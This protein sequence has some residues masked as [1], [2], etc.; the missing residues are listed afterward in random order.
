MMPA[1]QNAGNA[2]YVWQSQR[3]GRGPNG[4]M[5]AGA[6]SRAATA[7]ASAT[8][9][10][11]IV[12][13]VVDAVR[14]P[15]AADRTI[16][17]QLVRSGLLLRVHRSNPGY[18]HRD[19][20]VPTSLGR[21]AADKGRLPTET[22]IARTVR[23]LDRELRRAGV[24]GDVTGSSYSYKEPRG[25]AARER[26]YRLISD[27][28]SIGAFRRARDSQ[29]FVAVRFRS[30]QARAA[31]AELIERL[32]AAAAERPYDR[33]RLHKLVEQLQRSVISAADADTAVN[34][35]S[36]FANV[37]GDE[38]TLP[39]EALRI[40]LGLPTA[41]ERALRDSER[42]DA[43][44]RRT[45]DLVA[46]GENPLSDDGEIEWRRTSVADHRVRRAAFGY[47]DAAARIQADYH[48]Q[49][50][51]E[52][53]DGTVGWTDV[54]R[55][56]SDLEPYVDSVIET[57]RA[58]AESLAALAPFERRARALLRRWTKKHQQVS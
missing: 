4:D 20:F 55:A 30:A 58:F 34:G 45:L 9:A 6:A 17:E 46:A 31:K 48:Q 29:Q 8:A 37:A 21:V 15:A 23:A 41:R 39:L 57:N 1:E 49:A 18:G 28:K 26:L 24:D 22:E 16:R 36:P 38:H 35:L 44:L 27:R 10:D 51:F 42:Q 50:I 25:D 3:M 13:R 56:H 19:Y 33:Q 11:P 54:K 32:T 5:T 2:G 53:K 12:S 40:G 47:C 43:D 7:R 14:G 52:M